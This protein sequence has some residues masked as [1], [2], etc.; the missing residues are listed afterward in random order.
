MQPLARSIWW[1]G[2][3]KQRS[4]IHVSELDVGSLVEGYV[5]TNFDRSGPAFDASIRRSALY[6]AA[7]HT[8]EISELL[9]D[10]ET[11]RNLARVSARLQFLSFWH[12]LIFWCRSL[13]YVCSYAAGGDSRRDQAP[14]RKNDKPHRCIQGV[15]FLALKERG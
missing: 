14:G 11:G 7:G 4:Q 9:R 1:G 6:C 13:A 15:D 2:T 8:E 10:H 5:R 3:Y 12:C